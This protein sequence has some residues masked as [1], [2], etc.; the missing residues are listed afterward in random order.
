MANS[1]LKDWTKTVLEKFKREEAQEPLIFSKSSELVLSL[2]NGKDQNLLKDFQN[3]TLPVMNTVKLKRIDA[4]NHPEIIN[5]FMNNSVAQGTKEFMIGTG[6]QLNKEECQAY[7][8]GIQAVAQ[9]VTDYLYLGGFIMDQEKFEQVMISCKHLK[10]LEFNNWIIPTDKEC[11]F[12]QQL[13]DSTIH[14]ILFD[15]TGSSITSKWN[16]D[17]AQRFKNIIQGLSKEQ[18]IKENLKKIFL[19]KCCVSIKDAISILK[20]NGLTNTK[21]FWC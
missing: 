12:S 16:E 9:K 4:F 18:G 8:K 13:S 15:H 11:D 21:V 10:Y 19:R 1:L 14:T 5:K 20:E 3:T 2:N 7:I 17:G 6:C